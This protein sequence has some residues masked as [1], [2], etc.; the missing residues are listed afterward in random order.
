M[1]KFTP[2]LFYDSAF[3]TKQNMQL[4]LNF[5]LSC[6]QKK[7]SQTHEQKDIE[8]DGTKIFRDQRTPCSSREMCITHI[9]L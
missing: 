6:P 3:L 2:S 8:K 4:M 7:F 1:K 5:T 9:T